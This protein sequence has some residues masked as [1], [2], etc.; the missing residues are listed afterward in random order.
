MRSAFAL[1]VLAAACGVADFDVDQDIPEQRI[2]GSPLGG[3]LGAFFELPLALDIQAEI[4]AME[5][6]PI[7]SVTLSS[8]TLDIVEDAAQSCPADADWAFLDS[9]DLYVESTQSGTQLPRVRL[10]SATGPGAVAR[11]TFQPVEPK[12][13][14]V[15]YINE[16]AQ[17]TADAEGS[18]PPTNVCY[19]GKAVFRVSP[20]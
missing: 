20:L 8:L 18:A 12:V 6:G 14:L 5:T 13:N 10:A 19:T 4:Q 15:D 16:G 2:D 9:V 11:L 7:D 1:V 17:L 3:V